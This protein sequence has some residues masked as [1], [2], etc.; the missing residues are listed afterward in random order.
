MAL[1]F[2]LAALIKV[3]LGGYDEVAYSNY[4]NIL[5]NQGIKGIRA[6]I[7]AYPDN[8]FL[9]KA[10]SP[11]RILFVFIG[12]ISC[13]LLGNCGVENLALISFFSGM[14][15]VIVAFCLFRKWFTPLVAFAA[16]V[17]VII[18]PLGIDLSKRALQDSFFALIVISSIL[19]YHNCW[20]RKKIIDSVILGLLILA[21]FL[22]KESMVFIYPCFIAAGIYYWSKNRSVQISKILMPLLLAPLAYLVVISWISGGMQIFVNHYLFYGQN[23]G[24]IEYTTRFQ[25]GPWFRYFADFMLVSPLT[26]LFSIIGITAPVS[27]KQNLSGRKIASLCFL[28]GLAVFSLLPV[29]NLRI[30][31]FLDVFLRAL[32]VIGALSIIERIRFGRFRYFVAGLLICFLI[33]SEIYQFFHLFVKSGIYDPIT[34]ELIKAN[35]FVK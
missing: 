31:F 10:P 21:G 18:S 34:I 30:V 5:N 26:F 25:E 23:A 28:S 8:D 12:L 22:T 14:A 6:L 33:S 11:L 4:T 16:T 27:D 9:R 17:L 2:G 13:K 3:N 19:F 32:A 1:V 24:K 20:T 35:G 7:K 15:L 29:M